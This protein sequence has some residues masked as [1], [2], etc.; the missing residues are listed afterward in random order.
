MN[1][2]K[3]AIIKRPFP[4]ISLLSE[5]GFASFLRDR[6]FDVG[7]DGVRSFVES[8]LIENLDSPSGDF[9][10]F[11]I[12]PISK[13]FR[14]MEIGLDSGIRLA[15]VDPD[16]LKKFIN[17][18]WDLRTNCLTDFPKSSVCIQFNQQIFPLLLWLECHLLPVIRGSRPD[19]VSL[20]NADGSQWDEWRKHTEIKDWLDIYSISAE[21]LSAWRSDTLLDAFTNDPAP[22][23]YFLLRSM[24]YDQRRQFKGRLRLAYDLY[25]LAEMTRLFLERVS[26]HSVVKEWDPTGHPDTPWVERFYG[27]QPRFGSPEFLRPVVRHF[28]LDPA[29]RV[30]WLVEGE[31]EEGF[32]LRY[33]GRLGANINDFV[34]IRNFRGDGAFQKNIPAITADL[35][36]ARKEQC[37]VTLTFDDDSSRVRQR[38]EERIID[39]LVNMRFA[40]NKPDFELGNFE[41]SQLVKVATAW[42]SDLSKP[43]KLSQET[44]VKEVSN[45]ISDSVTFQKAL[46]DV[47]HRNEEE[48]RLS[49]GTKWGKRLADCLI[50][51]RDSEYE[52]GTYSEQSLSKIERQILFILRNS[53]PFIDYP[54]S[55]RNLDP[56]SL[57]IV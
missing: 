55:I 14:H 3:E 51:A 13:L 20:I 1:L 48:F 15:G 6:G 19:V 36:A 31:T 8:G 34:T 45:R 33:T 30:R 24:P 21:Q 43:I 16:K 23:L 4:Q 27:S 17:Q 9:H 7:V 52:A 35:Q 50:D 26:N 44:L 25:E 46:N 38:L 12:W 40:L 47:L 49:K 57:E 5:H 22:G 37:F 56:A 10:P 41:V 53:E 11:Q 2:I 42:A 54:G 39:G 18:N 32:I 28:G 29:F